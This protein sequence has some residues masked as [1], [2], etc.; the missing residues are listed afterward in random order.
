MWN[1]G[2]LRFKKF[3]VFIFLGFI[4]MEEFLRG[5]LGL[6]IVFGLRRVIMSNLDLGKYKVGKYE[7]YLV[8]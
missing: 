1:L 7:V 8:S 2:D 4:E 3:N 6:Y 5:R